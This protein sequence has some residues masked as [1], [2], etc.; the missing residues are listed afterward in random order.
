MSRSPG[1]APTVVH[2]EHAEPGTRAYRRIAFA[3]FLAG[4]TTFSHTA[5]TR[6]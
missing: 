3:L 6:R 4:F 2:A 1:P 5:L